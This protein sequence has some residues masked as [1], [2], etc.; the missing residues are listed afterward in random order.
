MRIGRI[1][2]LA[3]LALASCSEAAVDAA[4]PSPS[5]VAPACVRAAVDVANEGQKRTRAYTPAPA[6]EPAAGG[7]GTAVTVTGR[8]LPAGTDIV[9]VAL[10]GEGDCTIGT[11]GY[12]DHLLGRARTDASGS[13]SLN[14]V[15]PERFAPYGG[16]DGVGDVAL[17]AGRYYLFVEPCDADAYCAPGRGSDIGGPFTS[18]G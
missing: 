15:W 5:A 6:I 1:A 7:P 9:V 2:V 4:D 17:P 8:G 12:G 16:R 10:Y 14:A 13:V 18:S 11:A 3:T